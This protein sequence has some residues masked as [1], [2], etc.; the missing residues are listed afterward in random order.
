MRMVPRPA[1]RARPGGAPGHADC[2]VARAGM[3]AATVAAGTWLVSVR[4]PAPGHGLRDTGPGTWAPGHGRPGRTRRAPAGRNACEATRSRH[5]AARKRSVR[6]NSA[7]SRVP[8]QEPDTIHRDVATGR[9]AARCGCVQVRRESAGADAGRRRARCRT[10]C[11]RRRVHGARVRRD[12]TGGADVHDPAAC[13]DTPARDAVRPA[14]DGPAVELAGA[15][16]RRAA[17]SAAAMA[18][19][20]DA[21]ARTL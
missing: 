13:I 18:A 3:A 5:P 1:R 17:A 19:G 16:D 7:G 14:R 6:G 8:R 10:G 15:R 4:K 20:A 21:R 12:R 11:R 9:R 2:V